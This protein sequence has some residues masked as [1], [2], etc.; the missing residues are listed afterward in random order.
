MTV[1]NVNGCD[2]CRKWETL[3]VARKKKED[4]GI[5]V[6]VQVV[7]KRGCLERR[8]GDGFFSL[9]VAEIWVEIYVQ[10]KDIRG[11]RGEIKW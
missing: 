3:A 7:D 10:Y 11:T 5:M 2:E 6:G 4:G 9:F 8:S 1:A